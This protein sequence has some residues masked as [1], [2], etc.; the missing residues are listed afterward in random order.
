[1]KASSISEFGKRH[2]AVIFQRVGVSP[3]AMKVN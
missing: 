3:T 1:M 2:R